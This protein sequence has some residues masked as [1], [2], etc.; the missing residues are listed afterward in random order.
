MTAVSSC[1][2]WVFLA[3]KVILKVAQSVTAP[4]HRPNKGDGG[5]RVIC[6]FA[7]LLQPDFAGPLVMGLTDISQLNQQLIL[8]NYPLTYL[9]FPLNTVAYVP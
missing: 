9:L 5:S 7:T 8:T 1:S 4:C 6:S 2:Q 3:A